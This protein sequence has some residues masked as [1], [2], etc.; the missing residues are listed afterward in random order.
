MNGMVEATK[1]GAVPHKL[2]KEKHEVSYVADC[3]CG[4]CDWAGWGRVQLNTLPAYDTTLLVSW[5]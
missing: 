5:D 2:I 4:V 3:P 1:M